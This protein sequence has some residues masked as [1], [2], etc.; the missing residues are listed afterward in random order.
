MKSSDVVAY[1]TLEPNK[2]ENVKVVLFSKILE[3]V[4]GTLA[5]SEIELTD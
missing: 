1:G 5:Y 4:P 3:I 2:I